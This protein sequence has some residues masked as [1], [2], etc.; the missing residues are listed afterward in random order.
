VPRL[1]LRDA[2]LVADDGTPGP[3][4]TVVF[5]P[6]GVTSW[7]RLRVG[8]AELTGLETRAEADDGSSLAVHR[9]ATVT[10]MLLPGRALGEVRDALLSWVLRCT[11][12]KIQ[13]SL[14][15]NPET[16]ETTADSYV[17]QWTSA[18]APPFTGQRA[19]GLVAAAERARQ[20]GD[21]AQA[22]A[23]LEAVIALGTE[24]LGATAGPTIAAR[25]NLAYT[26]A[27]DGN[28]SEAIRTYW[29]LL[30]DASDAALAAMSPGGDDFTALLSARTNAMRNLAM[31][32]NPGWRP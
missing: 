22:Q 13:I 32:H 3:R 20:A 27:L 1:K 12:Q 25:N 31:L 2:I 30:D 26:L 24:R 9:G 10:R 19:L 6:F 7:P 15:W 5:S 18:T 28:R 14:V 8:W 4:R 16:G 21:T 29:S 11:G 17:R 23:V